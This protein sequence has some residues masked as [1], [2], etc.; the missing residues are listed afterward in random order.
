LTKLRD[1]TILARRKEKI[2]SREQGKNMMG[3]NEKQ[4]KWHY[5]IIGGKIKTYPINNM[6]RGKI[7]REKLK[8]IIGNTHT[9]SSVRRK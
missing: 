5:G 8:N 2:E 1:P 3:S 7:K 9:Y 6:T 4:K